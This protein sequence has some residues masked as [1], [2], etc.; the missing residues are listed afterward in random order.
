[1]TFS[2]YVTGTD[3]GIGKTLASAALLHALRGHGLRAAGMKP[4][5][6]GISAGPAGRRRACSA[7]ARTAR[8]TPKIT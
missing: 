1:M 4:V 7:K 8:A 2:L 6:A 3:T 5:A